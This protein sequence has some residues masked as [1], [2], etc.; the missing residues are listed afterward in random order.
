MKKKL[1][2]KIGL[3]ITLVIISASCSTIRRVPDGQKLLI[4]NE[5]IAQIEWENAES[6]LVDFD[7]SDDDLL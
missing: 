2:V 6:D 5:I 3:F 7:D 1:H 4:E